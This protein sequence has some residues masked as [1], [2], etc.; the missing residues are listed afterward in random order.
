MVEA[1]IY[2][3]W[4]WYDKTFATECQMLTNYEE[5]IITRQIGSIFQGEKST[6]TNSFRDLTGLKKRPKRDPFSS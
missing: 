6:A 3:H 4:F 1:E 2:S 5:Q